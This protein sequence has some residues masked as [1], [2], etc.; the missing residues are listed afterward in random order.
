MCK[1]TLGRRIARTVLGIVVFAL[2]VGVWA[3]LWVS[4]FVSFGF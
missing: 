1:Q 4:P 3:Y 2:A